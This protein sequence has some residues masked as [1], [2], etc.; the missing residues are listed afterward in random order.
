MIKGLTTGNAALVAAAAQVIHD[1]AADV[2]GNNIPVTGGTYN[3]DGLTLAEV[4][5]TATPDPAV[6]AATPAPAAATA[7]T[8]A[9]AALPAADAPAAAAP[10]APIAIA[11]LPAAA[12]APDSAAVDAHLAAAGSVP[13]ADMF[14]HTEKFDAHFHHLWG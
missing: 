3:P 9:A 11:A 10:A 4:L 2:G 1:N 5:S 14:Q 7:A 6:A 8:T 13:G 12:A